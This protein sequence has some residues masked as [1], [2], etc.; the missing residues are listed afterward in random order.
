MGDRFSH[1]QGG[2]NEQVDLLRLAHNNVPQFQKVRPISRPPSRDACIFI[3][4]YALFVMGCWMNPTETELMEPTTD[5]L[6]MNYSVL[7]R[8]R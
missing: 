6:Q 5:K 1:M 7:V 4:W 8:R 3:N 2:K